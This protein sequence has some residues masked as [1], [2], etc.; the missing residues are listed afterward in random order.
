MLVIVFLVLLL[1]L[2]GL[3]YRQIAS[4]L[5]VEAVRSKQIFRDQGSMQAAAQA[6]ALLESGPP[7]TDP[8]SYNITVTTNTGSQTYTVVI[9]SAGTGQWAVTASPAVGP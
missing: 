8:Y 5:R 1:S 3:T 6:L 9:A 7:A 4:A 2:L